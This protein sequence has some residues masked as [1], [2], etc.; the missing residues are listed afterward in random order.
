MAKDDRK[1]EP[2]AQGLQA[3]E[4]TEG[5]RAEIAHLRERLAEQ[6]A[7]ARDMAERRKLRDDGL[8]HRIRN[9][10]ALVKSVFSRT[11]GAS[12]SI[13]DIEMHF[14]GR[15]DVLARYQLP[16][17]ADPFEYVDLE[18]LI[19]NEFQS[20]SFGYADG[21]SIEGPEV[22][23]SPDQAQSLALA[24]HELV[25]NCFKFGALSM[26]G[27]GVRIVWTRSD[28]RVHIDWAETGVPVIASDPPRAGFGWE[29]IEEGLPYQADATTALAL[30]AGGFSCSISLPLLSG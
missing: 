25:T 5:L 23:I 29:L 8:Q 1:P 27:A 6:E 21:I 13:E 28:D 9:T 12:R 14:Q 17:T 3:S 10:M 7:Q 18:E 16:R 20:F 26:S 11:V 2:P 22:Q 24:M 15:L 4:E 19:R 30:K